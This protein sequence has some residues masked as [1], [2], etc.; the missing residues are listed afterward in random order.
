MNKTER[1]TGAMCARGGLPH[2]SDRH[3]ACGVL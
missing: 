3:Q 2:R 1:L